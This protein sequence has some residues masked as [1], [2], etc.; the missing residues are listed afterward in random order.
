MALM[1]T[2]AAI[3]QKEFIQLRDL[4][5]EKTGVYLKPSKIN[6]VL[7]RL[8]NRLKELSLDSFEKYYQF[9][10]NPAQKGELELFINSITTNET[11]FFRNDNQFKFLIEKYIPQIIHEKAENKSLNIW[12][13]AAST[14]EEAYTIAMILKQYIPK[15]QSWKINIHASDINS[16]VLNL[17]REGI[18]LEA[19]LKKLGTDYQKKYFTKL[20]DNH[21]RTLYKINDE[22]KSTVKFFQHNL[23]N[24]IKLSNLDII[25]LSNVLIYFDLKSKQKVIDNIKN[26]LNDGGYLFLGQS[27]SL[28]GSKHNFNLVMPST[29]RKGSK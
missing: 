6:L 11:Y 9:I 26:T 19:K 4:M 16:E 2:E 5:Y 23:L 29:F 1:V 3:S 20:V 10:L 13:A 17:A 18:Y 14:G 8:R 22:I 21:N 25:F 24:P 15:I 12:S 28:M 27:E 7:A